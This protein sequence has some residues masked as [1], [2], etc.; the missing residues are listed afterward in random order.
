MGLGTSLS[1]PI[2]KLQQ[3]GSDGCVRAALE[4]IGRQLTTKGDGR[5]ARDGQKRRNYK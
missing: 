2:A 3:G 5:R 1:P 4:F